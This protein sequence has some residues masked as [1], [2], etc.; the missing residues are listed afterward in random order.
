MLIPPLANGGNEMRR[1]LGWKVGFLPL[2]IVLAACTARRP[3]LYDNEK[4]REA[5][6]AAVERDIEECMQRAERYK[7]SG[8]SGVDAREV[9]EGTARG[10]VVGAAAGAAGGAVVGSAG[11]GAAVGAASG[12]AAGFMDRIFGGFTRREPDPVYS[13]YVN[14][15]LREKGYEPIGWR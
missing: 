3:V 13:N 10:A 9:A 15:C 14:R 5:G 11:R 6:E 7:A 2:L 1:L 8:G 4:V 12:G